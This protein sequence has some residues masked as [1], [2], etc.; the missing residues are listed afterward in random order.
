MAMKVAL[1][2]HFW[3]QVTFPVL[4]DC[5][6]DGAEQFLDVSFRVKYKR[7]DET[8][9]TALLQRV[10]ATRMEAMRKL[11]SMQGMEQLPQ[12]AAP[13]S[14]EV[15]ATVKEQK[16]LTPQPIDDR[17]IIDQV[18]LGWDQVLG[19]EDQ[20]LPFNPDNLS[21]TLATL[22]CAGAIVRRF[23]DLHQKVAEKNFARPS[24]TSPP[25]KA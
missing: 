11:T 7:L 2:P 4:T 6:D 22:G 18:M 12:T 25:T 5:G 19:D 24:V 9:Y 10:Q 20:A 3:A 13:S 16:D 15:D 8:E 17:Q 14:E 1:V 21:R 23:L